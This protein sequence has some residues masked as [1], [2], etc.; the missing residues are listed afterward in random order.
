M[1]TLFARLMIIIPIAVGTAGAADHDAVIADCN[2]CH[3]DGGVSQWSDV[4]TIAGLS[5]FYHADQLYFYRDEERPCEE[6]AFMQGAKAGQTSTMCAATSGLSDEQIDAIAAHYAALEFVPAAQEFDADR[7]AA[8]AAIH[9]RDCAMCHSAGG[10]DPADDAGI[11]AGQWTGYL[12]RT[13]ALYR[14]G[15]REQPA[16][17]QKKLDGLSDGDV[18]ALLHYYASQQ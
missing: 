10:S 7:A 13:I 6:A 12:A 5:E 1:K 3:G 9:E 17:M 14:S 15:E 16:P 4:P 8:G 11:L 2:G 18:E